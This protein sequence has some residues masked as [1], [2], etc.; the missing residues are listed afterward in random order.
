MRRRAPTSTI[1]ASRR[2]FMPP[3]HASHMHGEQSWLCG[4][5]HL[6]LFP[7]WPSDHV[8]SKQWAIF[9]SDMWDASWTL[10]AITGSTYPDELL[11]A[12]RDGV[13]KTFRVVQIYPTRRTVITC[14][15][16]EI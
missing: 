9:E 16:T 11:L 5:R 2:N 8:A 4:D 13:E 15:V 6:L 14:A 3:P 10:A 1:R 7:D 12:R